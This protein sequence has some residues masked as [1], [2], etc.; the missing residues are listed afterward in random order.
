MLM[1]MGISE[2]GQ[3]LGARTG[4]ERK[5]LGMSGSDMFSQYRTNKS[6]RYHVAAEERQRG[7][8]D[9][10]CNICSK[11]GHFAKDCKYGIS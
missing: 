8:E 2:E 10:R 6:Q 9:E 5:G 7:K 3:A 1:E 4:Q 11:S